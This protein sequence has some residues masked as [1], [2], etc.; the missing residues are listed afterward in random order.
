MAAHTNG[1][2][3][4]TSEIIKLLLVLV[5]PP[6][7]Q[8]PTHN[9]PPPLLLLLPGGLCQ[10]FVRYMDLGTQYEYANICISC[11]SIPAVEAITFT[12]LS[13]CQYVMTVWHSCLL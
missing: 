5:P 12:V 11:I 2:F 6:T 13:D 4:C 9:R 3:P 1:Y 7:P 8:L 10:F